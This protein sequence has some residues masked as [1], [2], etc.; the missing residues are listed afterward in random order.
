MIFNKVIYPRILIRLSDNMGILVQCQKG[1]FWGK[2]QQ[3][4]LLRHPSSLKFNDKGN[5]PSG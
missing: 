5:P 3:R 4:Y 1:E 2:F